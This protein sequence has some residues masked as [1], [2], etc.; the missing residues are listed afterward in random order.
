M[1]SE[2]VTAACVG[3]LSDVI[4]DKGFLGDKLIELS[5]A[6]PLVQIFTTASRLQ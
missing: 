2:I 1:A 3:G 4:G 5:R 6:A